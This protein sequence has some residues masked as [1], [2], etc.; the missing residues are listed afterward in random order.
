MPYGQ[1]PGT[2]IEANTIPATQFVAAVAAPPRISNVAVTSNSYTPIGGNL[3]SATGG[4]IRITGTDFVSGCSVVV[5]DF[6][7]GTPANVASAVSFVSST[8]VNAQLPAV[9]AGTRSVFLVN[10]NGA[11]AV[12]VAAVN[13]S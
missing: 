9:T 11:V 1:L 7:A 3:S 4:F 8:Q 13:Y 10:P 6:A 12:R 5:G 2:A